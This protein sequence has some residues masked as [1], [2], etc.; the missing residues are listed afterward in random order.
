MLV[1]E[2]SEYA[3][4]SVDGFNT[5]CRCEKS[6]S[7]ACC[8]PSSNPADGEC[9][10]GNGPLTPVVFRSALLGEMGEAAGVVEASDATDS[11]G[12]K[13]RVRLATDSPPDDEGGTARIVDLLARGVV[14]SS[15]TSS[16]VSKSFNSA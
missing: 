2:M 6:L 15:S 10:F 5:S 11:W 1:D 3:N 12:V 13:A 14:S 9:S 7:R 16:S 8:R 4:D